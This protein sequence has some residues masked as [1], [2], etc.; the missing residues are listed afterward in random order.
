MSNGS[1]VEVDLEELDHH[2]DE[3]KL[4]GSDVRSCAQR[5]EALGVI[6]N[7]AFGIVG[8][9]VAGAVQGWTSNATQLLDKCSEG[10]ED[11][12][13]RLADSYQDYRDN[14]KTGVETFDSIRPAG[15]TK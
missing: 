2:T 5:A 15:G 13:R 3:V 14:E 9:I 7:Q 12:A 1:G 6:G 11:I 8:Q 10:A 4:I